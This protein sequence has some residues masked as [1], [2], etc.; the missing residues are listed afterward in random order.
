MTRFQYGCN[1]ISVVPTSL[2]GFNDNFDLTGYEDGV[3]PAIMREFPKAK[4]GRSEEVEI[5]ATV[6]VLRESHANDLASACLQ[7][8]EHYELGG[9]INIGTGEE[10]AIDD[11]ADLVRD[12]VYPKAR[13]RIDTSKAND[14][15]RKVLD[16]SKLRALGWRHRIS[17]RNGTEGTYH[18]FRM[19]GSGLLRI[20][21]EVAAARPAGLHR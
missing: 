9:H 8:M 1:A 17:L 6:T 16:A 4:V 14:M 5:R 10:L 11:L 20:G 18:W 21:G 7:L 12:V 19:A 2:Y 15:L 13:I 3:V